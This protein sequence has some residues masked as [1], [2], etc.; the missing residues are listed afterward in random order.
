MYFVRIPKILQRLF[1]SVIWCLPNVKKEL[2]LTFDD[3]PHPE[4][5]PWVLE[6]L[7]K[8]KAKA[9]FFCLGEN[10]KRYPELLQRIINE[11]HSVGN[12][13]YAHLDGWKTK[14]EDFLKDVYKAHNIIASPLFRPPYGKLTSMQIARLQTQFTIINWSLM[15]GDFDASISSEQ[16]FR[17]LLKA[18][19]GDIVCL[20]DNEQSEQHLKW[21]LPKFL[22]QYSS[23]VFQKI[24]LD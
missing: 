16:C 9:T 7:K 8:H 19:S 24:Q 22:D 21:I 6:Q 4:I 10:V 12:H 18:K 11:G 23:F 13:S 20:H 14:D 1:S 17:N 15:P 2:Y 5:T 3:G